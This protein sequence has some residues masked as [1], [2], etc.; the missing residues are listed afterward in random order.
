MTQ[1][2]V[3]YFAKSFTGSRQARPTAVITTF[4][5]EGHLLNSSLK[6]IDDKRWKQIKKAGGMLRP[7][8]I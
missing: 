8:C 1:L 6:D 2:L 5:A 7:F 3:Y 4:F